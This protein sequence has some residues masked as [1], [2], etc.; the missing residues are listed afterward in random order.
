MLIAFL[1]ILGNDLIL[2]AVIWKSSASFIE[3][4]GQSVN[5]ANL[6]WALLS[7]VRDTAGYMSEGICSEKKAT[8]RLCLIPCV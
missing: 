2:T 8:K 3:T 6:L 4:A 1:L 7:I 5:L